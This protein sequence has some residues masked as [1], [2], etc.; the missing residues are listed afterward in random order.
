V[1]AAALLLYSGDAERCE[2]ILEYWLR[3]GC[4]YAIRPT[5]GKG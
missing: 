2:R 5:V 4:N 1:V 3:E